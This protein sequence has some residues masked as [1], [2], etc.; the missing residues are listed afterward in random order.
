[1]SAK[2]GRTRIVI[3]SGLFVVAALALGISRVASPADAAKANQD[4][5]WRWATHVPGV[6]T[7]DA[8][9]AVEAARAA[10]LDTA[11]V[12]SVVASGTGRG[13]TRLVSASSRSGSV[14]FAVAAPD[15]TSSF[16]CRRPAA[17]EAIVIRLIYG[18]SSL[19]SVDQA[20]LVGVGRG[21]VGSVSVTTEDGTVRM[22]ALN[23]WR[24]F[25]YAAVDAGSFTAA[26]SAYGKNGSLL[27][28]VELGP[29]E[30][31]E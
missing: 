18:G 11:T 3:A 19:D 24:G 4:R 31:P 9:L 2:H 20:T 22:L 25:G 1:M 17:S 28:H 5:L 7:E 10:G 16:S 30:A 13:A 15:Q 26:L 29:L 8:P 6:R 23:R 21:D 27:Q 14:C 12:R